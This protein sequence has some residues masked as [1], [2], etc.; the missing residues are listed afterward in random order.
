ME[1][2]LE[3]VLAREGVKLCPDKS[4]VLS[5]YLR[6]LEKLSLVAFLLEFQRVV[7]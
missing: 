6:L 4:Q 7:F 3:K 2:L 1:L 5:N